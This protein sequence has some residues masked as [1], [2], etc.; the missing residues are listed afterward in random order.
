MRIAA[1]TGYR[2]IVPLQEGYSMSGGRDLDAFDTTVVR[3]DTDAG[4]VGWGEITPLGSNYLPSYPEGARTGLEFLSKVLIGEDPTQLDAI[5]GAMDAKLRGHPYVKTA[6]DLACWDILGKVA[7]LPVCILLG[8]RFG[9]NI[10]LYRSITYDAP[11]AMVDRIRKFRARGHRQ[12]QL[13]VGG[14]ADTDILRIRESTAALEPGEQLV[15]DANGGWTR[16]EA[17]RVVHAVD[18]LDVHIEQPCQTYEECLTI[19]SRTRN[20]FVLDES[21]DS[22][23]ALQRG[24]ADGAMDGVNIK[25]SRVGGL[26]RARTFRDLCVANGIKVTLEDT[27][28]TDISAAAVTHLAHSTQERFRL[29]VTLANLKSDVRIAKESPVAVNGKTSASTLPG[30]GVEPIAEMLG[31]PVF[32]VN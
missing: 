30:L 10:A 15:A 21:M 25:I 9:A 2:V 13:K 29:S 17:A 20:P 26:T 7:N 28:G 12:F 22:L 32:R 11:A 24:I 19:R 31:E 6:L 23:Q 5:N 8:G 14:D 1:V 18:D 27:A 16:A 3:V 4:V